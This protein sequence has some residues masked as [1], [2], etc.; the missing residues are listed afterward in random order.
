[1]YFL[2]IENNYGKSDNLDNFVK[3]AQM[4]NYDCYRAMFEAWNAQL[5]KPASGVMLWMT[6]PAQHSMVCEVPIFEWTK[7]LSPI[8]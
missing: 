3:R 2:A 5:F 1:M 4:L 8:Y 7:K 6:H